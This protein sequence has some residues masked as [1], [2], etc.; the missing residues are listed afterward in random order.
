[1]SELLQL[2]GSRMVAGTSAFLGNKLI[3]NVELALLHHLHAIKLGQINS[4]A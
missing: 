2:D 1:M 3:N 4:T